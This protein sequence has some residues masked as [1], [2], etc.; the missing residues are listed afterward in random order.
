MKKIIIISTIIC[1]VF[2]VHAQRTAKDRTRHA[3]E[4]QKSESAVRH[5]AEKKEHNRA[6]QANKSGQSNARDLSRSK[7]TI[8][9][10]SHTNQ[11]RRDKSQQP[12][13][14][15]GN[16][17]P[18]SGSKSSH[19]EGNNGRV[20]EKSDVYRPTV[21]K[22]AADNHSGQ[23]NN[24]SIR[25]GSGGRNQA[26][27]THTEQRSHYTT[28][29]RQ[30]VRSNHVKG[31]HYQYNPVRYRQVHYHYHAP[32]PIHVTWTRRMYHD[33]R[34]MYPQF[35]YWYYPIGY[36]IVTIPFYNAYYH[37]GEVRNVYGRVYE[38]Y[39]S[40]TTDEYHLYFGG[41]YPYHD[42]TVIIPGRQAR[43]FSNHPELFFEGRY[44]WVTGLLSTFEGRPEL[45]VRRTHQVHLY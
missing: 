18:Y 31:Y 10:R 19:R 41:N 39:Y 16:I 1:F 30:A 4:K 20:R 25:A 23:R 27:R 7:Q 14:N 6:Y 13:R 36:Q 2:T 12:S 26:T 15:R 38:V 42:F 21:K 40:W 44:I 3:T 22:G 8:P 28:P 43:R 11:G 33:Y 35:R 9:S 29:N 32:K 37:I 5:P 24:Q 45:I 17:H 34:I